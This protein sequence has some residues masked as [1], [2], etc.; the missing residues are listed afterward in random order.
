M[1]THFLDSWNGVCAHLRRKKKK[2]REKKKKQKEGNQ[3]C[4]KIHS[5]GTQIY[6]GV[7]VANSQVVFCYL[8][9]FF[10]H[11]CIFLFIVKLLI[12]KL[13]TVHLPMSLCVCEVCVE[14]TLLLQ[15]QPL[16]LSR[17]HTVNFIVEL[18]FME[19]LSMVLKG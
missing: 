12:F 7:A 4:Y 13:L 3:Q 1:D 16:K 9:S 6:E 2:E 15:I 5:H 10:D 14:T 18:F 17:Y 11:I 19:S 8:C